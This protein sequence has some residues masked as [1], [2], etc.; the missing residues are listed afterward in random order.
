M[1]NG[2]NR[3][4]IRGSL[5]RTRKKARVCSGDDMPRFRDSV[6]DIPEPCVGLK[7][8]GRS[9]LGRIRS[10]HRAS[11]LA[12]GRIDRWGLTGEHQSV[13]VFAAI[14]VL[15]GISRLIYMDRDDL[16]VFN[17]WKSVSLWF[18][19]RGGVFDLKYRDY[20]NGFSEFATTGSAGSGGKIMDFHQWFE[21]LQA[22]A[23]EYPNYGATVLGVI[24]MFF[25]GFFG[26]LL[27]RPMTKQA[28]K[29]DEFNATIGGMRQLITAQQ[30]TIENLEELQRGHERD[31][32]HWSRTRAQLV[33]RLE[34]LEARLRPWPD[35]PPD[36]AEVIVVEDNI[37][38]ANAICRIV[39]H[40]GHEPFVTTGGYD[41]L[42]HLR[43][44]QFKLMI[45]DFGL[46]DMNGIDVAIQARR[47]KIDIPIIAI[48][49]VAEDINAMIKSERLT[50]AKMMAILP[51]TARAYDIELTI[52]TALEAASREAGGQG[53]G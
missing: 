23:K 42:R 9:L 40:L 12:Q 30:E 45:L 22:L 29:T 2:A 19:V 16:E 38:A 11:V 31:R 25:T 50:E 33:M 6:G 27:K 3:D 20:W 44:G 32:G 37:L 52:K 34:E 46:P 10:R 51:K 18:S 5:A 28:I 26:W 15:W 21:Q 41:A 47:E 8:H 36:N 48:T 49:G 53:D 14:T 35:Y 39:R 17:I 7:S 24:G 43:N 1:S 13:A 4:R